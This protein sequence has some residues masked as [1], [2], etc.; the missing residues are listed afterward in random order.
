M[1]SQK[2]MGRVQFLVAVV[3]L[4]LIAGAAT[5]TLIDS[6]NSS[7]ENRKVIPNTNTSNTNTLN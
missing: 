3:A 2:G 6:Y 5:Y 4:I 1:K 7:K